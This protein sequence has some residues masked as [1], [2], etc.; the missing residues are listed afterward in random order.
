MIGLHNLLNYTI[1]DAEYSYIPE[2]KTDLFCILLIYEKKEI[3]QN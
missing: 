3:I 2:N 1:H